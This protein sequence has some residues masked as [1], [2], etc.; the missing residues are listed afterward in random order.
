MYIVL[1]CGRCRYCGLGRPN[2][3]ENRTTMAYHHD[4]AF[5]RYM[6][7]PAR[8]VAHGHL[9]R[10]QSD[11]PSEQMGL[12]EPLGCV[13]NAHRRLR[14]RLADTAAVIGARPIGIMHA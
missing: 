11:T 7:I 6:K 10:V 12:A 8:A 4:G 13:I 1:P 9:F 2:L 14:I 3:C 5:A